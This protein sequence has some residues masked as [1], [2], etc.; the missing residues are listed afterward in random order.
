MSKESVVLK[1]LFSEKTIKLKRAD[2][3]EAVNGLGQTF[4]SLF[5][6][7]IDLSKEQS[8][9]KT[10][11]VMETVKDADFRTIFGSLDKNLDNLCLTKYQIAMFCQNY[12]DYLSSQRATFFLYKENDEYIVSI[13]FTHLNSVI[14]LMRIFG[15]NY[16]WNSNNH[17]RVVVPVSHF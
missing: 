13:V 8:E 7:E 5:N 12:K 10:V 3:L 6:E 16:D 2:S 11:A 4:K 9:E 1:R 14:G 17:P 15:L